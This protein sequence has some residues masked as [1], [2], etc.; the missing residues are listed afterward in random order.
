MPDQEQYD[1]LVDRELLTLQI[2][3]TAK[4]NKTYITIEEY[5]NVRLS[6]GAGL[7]VIESELLNDLVNNGRIFGEFRRSIKSTSVGSLNKVRDAAYY[8][9]MGVTET[10]RWSAVLV[11]TCPDCLS[12]HGKVKTWEEWEQSEFGLPR[13]GATVC[14]ENCHCVL[15][16]EK[17]TEIEPIF[18]KK[19][20]K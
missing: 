19:K 16:P 17:Y 20:K 1:S 15:V 13:S 7:D 8:S 11:N 12:Q 2:L 18:R 3:L 4:A 6:Q 14:R 10:Y 9:D 5:I